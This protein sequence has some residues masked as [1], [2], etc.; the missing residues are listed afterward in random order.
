MKSPSLCALILAA[1]TLAA[2]PKQRQP[3]VLFLVTRHAPMYRLYLKKYIR[4]ISAEG[5]QC[6]YC[7]WPELSWERIK[8]FNV[9]VVVHAT[10]EGY[11]GGV[12][13]D[14]KRGEALFQRFMEAGGGMLVTPVGVARIH[15]IQHLLEPYGA[16][17]YYERVTDHPKVLRRATPFRIMFAP[18][19]AIEPHPATKG[20]EHIWYATGAQKQWETLTIPIVCD[21]TW[22]VLVRGRPTSNSTPITRTRKQYHGEAQAREK[23]FDS[24]VPIFAVKD[25]KPGRLAYIAIP[26]MFTYWGGLSPG[27]ENVVLSAGIGEKPSHVGKLLTNAYRWLAEPSLASGQLG[28]FT[29]VPKRVARATSPPLEWIQK[30]SLAFGGP[31]PQFKGLIGAQ[32]TF[33][34]GRSDPAQYREAALEAGYSFVAFLEDLQ[35]IERDRFEEL[36]TRCR[37]LSDDKVAL[38]P[39][40]R[41][42]DQNGNSLYSFGPEMPFPGQA[43]LTPERTFYTQD[44][45]KG[46]SVSKY[47]SSA[48]GKSLM[49]S[50]L[51]SRGGNPIWN[52]INRHSIAVFTYEDGKLAEDV[53]EDLLELQDAG[54]WLSPL[55]IHLVC[56]AD[57]LREAASGDSFQTIFWEEN[58]A[59]LAESV[60]ERPN[61]GLYTYVTQ[62]PKIRAWQATNQQYTG[63]HWFDRPG[64]HWRIRL[65]VESA[66]GLSEVKIMDGDE[67][68]RRFLPRGVKRFS[69]DLDLLHQQQKELTLLVTDDAGRRAVSDVIWDSNWLM[70][71]YWLADRWN[72]GVYSQQAADSEW[73][74]SYHWTPAVPALHFIHGFMWDTLHYHINDAELIV[75]GFD[76]PPG[77]AITPY[78]PVAFYPAG[79]K[80][81]DGRHWEKRPD[82][83]LASQDVII[84]E[85]GLSYRYPDGSPLTTAVWMPSTPSDLVEGWQ[86]YTCFNFKYGMPGVC[87]VEGE[88]KALKDVP[89][90]GK[91]PYS[92]GLGWVSSPRTEDT[93]VFSVQHTGEANYTICFNALGGP[94]DQRVGGGLPSGSYFTIFPSRQGSATIFSLTDQ[95]CYRYGRRGHVVWGLRD[96]DGQ[97]AAGETLRWRYLSMTGVGKWNA[98]NLMAEKIRDVMGLDGTPGYDLTL[99]QGELI[100]QQFVCRIDG[101]GQGAAGTFPV[102]GLPCTLPVMVEN[103]N[104]RWTAVFYE[105]NRKRCR[106]I[107]MHRSVAYAQLGVGA[108]DTS[109]FVGHPFTCDQPEVFLNLVQ[110]GE[111]SFLLEIHNPTDERKTVRLARS[112]SFDL[113]PA[114]GFSID[115]D[116]GASVV[117]L[118]S[119]E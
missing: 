68:F 93:R 22:Q 75:P 26:R 7:S 36:R 86:R 83:P 13:E 39:G 65:D 46:R 71:D 74:F 90:S 80:G 88:L 8:A 47:H 9:I 98:S 109:L 48:Y 50:M 70:K 111:R 108:E 62:G 100:S 81:L 38:I 16:L 57:E 112:R 64:H 56:S 119:Q 3:A 45:T 115:V 31:S 53:S 11:T 118:I 113:A 63:F 40:L 69:A 102:D 76:G 37:E 41:V 6:D 35:R 59:T 54:N 107:A 19:D 29:T 79:S 72:K 114:G 106:P 77:N 92:A 60:H 103:L 49:G 25:V 82:R 14:F 23:G 84:S 34:G 43:L 32:S 21:S 20:V 66:A 4:Q 87:L 85:S 94:Q 117:R 89:L 67:L 116:P 27:M 44:R 78:C 110:T 51:H 101:K 5:I 95:L 104:D 52:Y 99:E 33:S 105:R 12:P 17:P 24:S 91:V 15:L 58:L 18:T 28:G 2:E 55:A 30:P 73:G 61:H 42:K 1:T 97:L 96:A 10:M